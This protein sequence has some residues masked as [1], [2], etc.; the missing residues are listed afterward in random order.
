[1]RFALS[2]NWNNSGRTDGEAIADEA[3]AIGFD[4][5]ELGFRTL[6]E[7][8]PGIKSRLDVIG[9]DSIHAY[10]PVPPGAPSGH[11]E[12]H[13]LLARDEDERAIARLLLRKTFECA[14]DLGAKV[15]VFHAGYVDL[16]TF[17][18]SYGAHALKAALA[19]AGGKTEDPRYAKVLARAKRLRAKRGAKLVEVFKREFAAVAPDLEKRHLVLALENLP[20]IEGFPDADEAE[21]LMAEFKGGPL[22][23]WFDTGHARV[24]ACHAWSVPEAEIAARVAP[25]VAGLHLNDV[26]DF[27]DD[28]RQPGW[29][30]VDF[31]AFKPL[32][33]GDVLR[34]FEPHKPVTADELRTSLAMIR[35]LWE[36]DGGSAASAL[37][38]SAKI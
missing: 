38:E 30:K 5:L 15:V 37:P 1:L 22:R 12:L 10:C 29:G 25:H 17:F 35:S 13:Q 24:R 21:T 23:L 33:Q 4:A 6:P 28:H 11:P 36:A 20:R 34:V 26:K 7:Q 31:A 3:A 19:K 9:V 27:D 32:A 16:V 18:T 8:L 14:E 2:T